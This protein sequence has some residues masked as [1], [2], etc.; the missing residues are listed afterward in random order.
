MINLWA[1]GLAMTAGA[2]ELDADAFGASLNGWNGKQVALYT[3]SDQVFGTH[4]PTTTGTPGGGMFLSVRV[5][6]RS[7]TGKTTGSFLELEFDAMGDLVS[8]QIRGGRGR[9]SFNTGRIARPAPA[10]GG[11]QPG[12][13]LVIGTPA[14]QRVVADLFDALDRELVRLAKEEEARKQDVFGRLF[15]PDR[16]CGGLSATLRHNLNLVL[17]HVR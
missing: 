17:R 2:V 9:R 15:G 6:C 12:E 5:D 4:L 1:A 16:S 7:R 13:G 3:M 14:T 8:G 10:G 11:G